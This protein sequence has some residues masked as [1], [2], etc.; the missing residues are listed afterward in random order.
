ML[1]QQ[2]LD[3]VDIKRR[4]VSEDVSRRHCT[5]KYYL[6]VQ[7]RA[8]HKVPICQK[9]LC[10]ILKITPRRLQKL[11]EKIKYNKPLEDGRG[12][13]L[14]RPNAIPDNVKNQIRMHIE[15]FPK[16][17][18]H[19][20]RQKTSKMWLNPDL[21]I[22]KMYVLFKEKY[23]FANCNEKLYRDIFRSDFNLRFGAPRSDTCTY[24]D[25]LYAQLITANSDQEVSKISTESELH[26]RR[27]EKAYKTLQEDIDLAKQNPN[28]TVLCTDLQQV[29]FCPTLQHSSVFYQRQYSCYNQAIHNMGTND[30]FMCFWHECI[31][32]R[33]SAEISSCLLKYITTYYTPMKSSEAD[34]K[35][36]VWS[37]RCV[38]Q[39]NNWRMISLYHYLVTMKYFSSVEQKFLI[40]GHSFLPCD[41]DF[42]LIEKKKKTSMVHHPK[43][44]I[45][46][47]ANARPS[48]SF[49]VCEMNTNDFKDLTPIES[50]LKKDP[51]LKITS[52]VWI[53]IS[54]DDPTTIRVRRSHNILQPWQYYS[55]LKKTRGV[56]NR[57]Q[58]PKKL[59]L[60]DLP[61]LYNSVLPIKK[62]KKRNLLDMCQYIPAPSHREFYENLTDE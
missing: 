57:C 28:T 8:G 20:S 36:I 31:A 58:P 38:G 14:N 26:H 47:I 46:V 34:R 17:E 39:N 49:C 21:S 7:L 1:C 52:Y 60:Q 9:M 56:Y 41:R 29:L 27:A 18:S 62:D 13:H 33:G 55:L 3:V 12:K 40:S 53:Q 5:V 6:P 42:A 25:R 59:T 23:P 19:Y 24:C 54:S 61:N 16:Q 50:S 37:D 43:Q 11:Q 2:C 44:W 30:V 51:E 45:E 10:Y 4:Y 15:S 35:L 48:K 22:K 32:K